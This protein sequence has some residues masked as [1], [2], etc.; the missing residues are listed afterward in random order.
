ME[1]NY[2]FEKLRVSISDTR[3]EMGIAGAGKI[4]EL[5]SRVLERKDEINMIFASAPSQMDVLNEMLKRDEIPWK[6]VNAFHMDEYIG[7][8]GDAPQSFGNYLRT[9]LF[10]KAPFKSVHYLDGNAADVEEECRRYAALLRRHPVDICVMGIGANG[11]LAFNDPG[12]ADFCDPLDVK[13][14]ECLDET[15]TWQQVHDGWFASYGDVPKRALTVTIPALVRAPYVVAIVPD[16]SKSE[17]MGRFFSEPIS[18]ELPSSIIRQHRGAWLYLDADSAS[19]V[20]LSR[21]QA[22]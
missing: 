3:T 14:N 1:K 22:R 17:I 18:T 9:R 16:S 8:P 21:L 7:L 11:H 20:A 5:M 10:Q 12:I 19:K 6:S 2:L 13:V 15:C 4:A